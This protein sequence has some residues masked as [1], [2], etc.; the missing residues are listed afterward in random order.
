MK[1]A[2][3]AALYLAAVFALAFV[4]AFFT[5]RRGEGCDAADQPDFLRE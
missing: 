5:G 1:A 4:D 3:A 2:P